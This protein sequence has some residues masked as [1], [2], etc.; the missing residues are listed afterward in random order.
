MKPREDMKMTK[1]DYSQNYPFWTCIKKK[2][3]FG[4]FLLVHIQKVT[5]CKGPQTKLGEM[6]F[7]RDRTME[8]GPWIFH[9]PT[10]LSRV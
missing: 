1:L 8:V 7:V 10:S 9:G 4:A 5:P 3:L 6:I 2:S